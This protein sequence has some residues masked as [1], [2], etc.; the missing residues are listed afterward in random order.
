MANSLQSKFMKFM[1][2]PAAD[3]GV[4]LAAL[5]LL[6]WFWL[7]L[8]VVG[9]RRLQEWLHTPATAE[10]NPDPIQAK[11]LARLVNRAAQQPLVP[12]T[13][14]S[15]SLLLQWFLKRQGIASQLRIG[16]DKTT[17]EF[18]AHAWVECAG[19][20]VNDHPDVAQRYA[21]FPTTRA[22]SINRQ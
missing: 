6:P 7:A 20:P 12:A 5:M 11:R 21:V 2:L 10:S 14:L 3:Q 22:E 15:R 17:S 8:R 16:I 9:L 18:K 19:A 1:T 4:F 13:C